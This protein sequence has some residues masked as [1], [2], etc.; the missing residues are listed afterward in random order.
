MITFSLYITYTYGTLA[1]AWVKKDKHLESQ[2]Y[3][4]DLCNIFDF[5]NV[6]PFSPRGFF[7]FLVT[8]AHGAAYRLPSF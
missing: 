8:V 5:L 2:K 3:Y 7:T 6:H 1:D 4:M